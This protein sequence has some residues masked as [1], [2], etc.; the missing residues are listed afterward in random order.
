[1][2]R[3][4]TLVERGGLR[5]GLFRFPGGD[6]EAWFTTR[7]G[8]RSEGPWRW[9]NVD[10]RGG[11]DPEAVDA[12]REA[13]LA[14]AGLTGLFLPR[15]VHGRGILI[16]GG[17]PEGFVYGP[18]AD[19]VVAGR[20]GPALGVMT[21]DCVPVLLCHDRRP[22]TAAVHAGWRGVAE[23]LV[24]AALEFMRRRWEVVGRDFG[25]Y[26]GPAIGPCCYETDED[27]A[28]RVAAAAG[29]AAVVRG[30]APKPKVDLVLA[31]ARQLEGCG[32]DPG[33]IWTSGLCT[34]CSAD[35]FYSY[36]R[37]GF[38]T[39]RMASFVLRRA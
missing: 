34:S 38:T 8:G 1:M 32:L 23:G 30:G 6:A 37:D 14:A 16:A 3:A 7:K 13:V 28:A 19:A 24:P 26:L 9:L 31:V 20:A 5:L 29:D 21:A 22:V 36:R 33:R 12:N 25:A 18:E 4:F 39:G 10:A 17:T 35:L 15:Q 27:V 2:I 11:D